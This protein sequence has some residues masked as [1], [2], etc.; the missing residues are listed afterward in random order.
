MYSVIKE[1]V[2][3]PGCLWLLLAGGLL[4][5]VLGRRK[6]GLITMSAGLIAFYVLSM[7]LVAERLVGLVQTVPALPEA[8]VRGAPAQAIV[9][10]SGGLHYNSPEY[11][12]MTVDEITLER[13]RYAARVHRL[14]GLP[15]YVSG[16]RPPGAAVTLA[17]AMKAALNDDF[18]I[19]DV[20]TEER[21][22]DTYE[23]AVFT[24]EILRQRDVRS[25]LLVTHASHMPRAVKAFSETGLTIIPAPTIFAHVS[26]ESPT[27]YLPRLSGL[28][29]SHYAIYEI[30]GRAW[31]ALRH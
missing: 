28:A 31:Y 18:G 24:A 8:E 25:V 22:L 1:A 7:P 17:G 16:G 23:N 4:L 12:G 6:A 20:T 3:P 14:T 11:G 29:Q 27:T 9:V 30:A 21:S 15:L 2:L 10:L 26:P 19:A 5:L 13:L